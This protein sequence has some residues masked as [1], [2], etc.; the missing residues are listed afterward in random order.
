MS[1]YKSCLEELL[2]LHQAVRGIFSQN[3]PSDSLACDIMSKC[4]C[5]CF[6]LSECVASCG[7]WVLELRSQME[8]ILGQ[9]LS[10]NREA[11]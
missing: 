9:A 5:I 6:S 10:F 2:L 1:G 8:V 11:S 7:D 4:V 3:P